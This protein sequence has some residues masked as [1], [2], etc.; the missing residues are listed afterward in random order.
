MDQEIETSSKLKRGISG[1]TLKMIAIVTMLID[2][3]GAAL[4]A[5][6]LIVHGVENIMYLIYW[7]MRVIGR[8]AFPIFIFLMVEGF[9][10]TR[11]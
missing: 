5:R 8:G 7:V 6:L 2:H 9:E 3:V 1:S 10:K 4:V 11:S